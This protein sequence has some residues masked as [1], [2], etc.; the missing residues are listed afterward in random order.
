MSVWARFVHSLVGQ[1]RVDRIVA[2]V[3][4]ER[5][6]AMTDANVLAGTYHAVGAEGSGSRLPVFRI[7]EKQQP[8]LFSSFPGI[9]R[10]R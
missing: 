5:A 10:R 2:N 8:A 6:A 1:C 4:R 7:G 3:M 9:A